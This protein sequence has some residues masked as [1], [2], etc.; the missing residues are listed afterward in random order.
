MQIAQ[1]SGNKGKLIP[2]LHANSINYQSREELGITD[3]NIESFQKFVAYPNLIERLVSMF[4]PNVVGHADKKLGIL[5][6]AVNTL[7]RMDQK[8]RL[9]LNT[10]FV[11]PPG[12][13]KSLLGREVVK[14]LPI[15]GM[16]RDKTPAVGE[17]AQ[18]R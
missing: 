2:F 6:S 16:Y 13:A 1:T 15:A 7:E 9:R 14:L 17:N 8:R 10:L 11:G 4:S 5:L 12:T 18:L 3:N